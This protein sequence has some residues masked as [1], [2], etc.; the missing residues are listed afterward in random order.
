MQTPENPQTEKRRKGKTYTD[1]TLFTFGI[2]IVIGLLGVGIYPLQFGLT[3]KY[4]SVVCT[5]LMLAGACLLIGGLLGFLFGVL[6]PC[7]KIR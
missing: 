7:S 6:A 2:V 4:V 3:G 1:R 5:A